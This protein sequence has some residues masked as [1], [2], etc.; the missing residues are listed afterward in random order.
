MDCHPEIARRADL[1]VAMGE[2]F[3]V[4]GDGVS[5]AASLSDGSGPALL[6]VLRA[7]GTVLTVELD[8]A[9]GRPDTADG[10]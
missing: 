9:E 5:I 7:V 4:P 2:E 3:A 8:V 1:V 10:D 6:T